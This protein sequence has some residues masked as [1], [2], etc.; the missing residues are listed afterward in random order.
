MGESSMNTE[1]LKVIGTYV[2]SHLPDWIRE[3]RNETDGSLEKFS[4]LERI[5][6][7]EEGLKHQGDLLEKLIHQ[8]DKRFSQMFVFLTTIF[9]VLG[10]L[11]SVYQFL[12]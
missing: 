8:L 9:I 6:R 5:V 12:A 11:M 1:E 2:K 3:T 7:V 10:T 4:L